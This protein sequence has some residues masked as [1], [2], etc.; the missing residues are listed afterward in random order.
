MHRQMLTKS[1]PSCRHNAPKSGSDTLPPLQTVS[2]PRDTGQP[3]PD[4]APAD[5]DAPNIASVRESLSLELIP[6]LM[7]SYGHPHA[8]VDKRGDG[9][10]SG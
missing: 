2:R 8:R 1:L 10:W 6:T 3:T 7:P 5:P 4:Y 9:L